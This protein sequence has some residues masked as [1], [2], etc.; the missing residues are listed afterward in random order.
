MDFGH[1]PHE[2]SRLVPPP[3]VFGWYTRPIVVPAAYKGL[4]LI[5]DLGIIDD[6][7]VT[8]L[9]GRRS[10]ARGISTTRISRPGTYI[11]AISAQRSRSSR[12]SRTRWLSR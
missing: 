2:F 10:A 3:D 8:Y 4:D 7:D 9:T 12:V 11:A 1:T 5:L 6:A